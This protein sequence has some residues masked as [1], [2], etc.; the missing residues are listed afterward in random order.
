MKRRWLGI[1][2]MALAASL[3]ALGSILMKIIP[4][5]TNLQ[6]GHLGI[7]RFSIAAPILWL[8]NRSERSQ[9]EGKPIRP[10]Q[11]LLLGGVFAIG[12]FSAVFALE[13]L[14]SSLYVIILYLYPSLVV[15]FSFI[16]GKQ[17]PKLFWVGLPLTTIGLFL[18]AYEFGVS[19][20]IDPLGF[21]YTIINAFGVAAYMLLSEK[22]LKGVHDKLF[23]TNFVLTGA[24]MAGLLMIPLVG[25]RLPDSAQGW[26]LL[27]TF[28]I[29]SSLA[30]IVFMNIA[31]QLMGA[32]RGSVIITLQPI[33][34]VLISTILLDEV[35]T[36]Q[37]WM[38][39]VIVIAAIVLLQISPDTARKQV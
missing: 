19:L 39:G 10:F 24:M 33:L 29:F 13:R 16:T 3:L 38:G 32:A 14:P 20:S 35:L 1:V 15:L 7:L 21:F 23:A 30:P 11:L 22:L 37:Q 25:F 34:T 4:Q 6:P 12:N 36:P 18:V 27:L 9:G 8:F 2:L 17:V 26:L 28:S 5:I 31:L